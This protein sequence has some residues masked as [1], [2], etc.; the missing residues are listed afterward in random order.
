MLLYSV[1]SHLQQGR[2]SFENC[3]GRRKRQ[4]RVTTA[5]LPTEVSAAAAALAVGGAIFALRQLNK[6]TEGAKPTRRVWISLCSACRH[7]SW[8]FLKGMHTVIRV[9]ILPFPV[10]FSGMR[11]VWR[12]WDLSHMQW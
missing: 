12:F 6:E 3:N 9:N 1:G 5:A 10:A 4:S 7:I 2:I 8:C 11:I